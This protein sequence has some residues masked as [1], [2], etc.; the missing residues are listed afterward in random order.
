MSISTS[1]WLCL[2]Q[3]NCV[4]KAPIDK[5][6]VYSISKS[7]EP[8]HSSPVENVSFQRENMVPSGGNS[9][10]KSVGMGKKKHCKKTNID[11][12]GDMAKEKEMAPL[13]VSADKQKTAQ[14]PGR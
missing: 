7:K 12:K 5:R 13:Q 8:S 1:E 14:Q 2:I 6:Q 9:K 4:N 10:M 11:S 3:M